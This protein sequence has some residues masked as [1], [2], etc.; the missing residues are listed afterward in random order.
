[1]DPRVGPRRKHDDA[2]GII[3]A[4]INNGYALYSPNGCFVALFLSNIGNLSFF[5]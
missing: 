4:G 5:N 2:V 3:L 1:V